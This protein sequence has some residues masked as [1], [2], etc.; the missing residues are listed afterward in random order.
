MQT[1]LNAINEY[2]QLAIK[3]AL[4]QSDKNNILNCEEKSAAYDKLITSI[5][6]Y[7]ADIKV[8]TI[9]ESINLIQGEQAND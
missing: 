6:Y 3:C 4:E 1:V 2:T 7:V 9:K 5:N 8:K